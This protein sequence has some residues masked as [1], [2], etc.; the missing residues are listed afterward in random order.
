MRLTSPGPE[1]VCTI[2]LDSRKFVALNVEY[3]QKNKGELMSEVPDTWG[4]WT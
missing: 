4:H 1:F 2:G 3:I